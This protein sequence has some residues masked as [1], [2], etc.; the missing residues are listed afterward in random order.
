MTG[1][2]RNQ[3]TRA[4]STDVRGA[5]LVE[6]AVVVL[7]LL[8]LVFGIIEFGLLMK[9]YLLLNHAAREGARF[10]AL[11]SP[12]SGVITR[13]Q[14]SAPTLNQSSLTTTLQKRAMG[15]TP[16]AWVALGNTTDGLHNDAGQGDEVRAYLTYSHQLATGGFFSWLFGSGTSVDIHGDM[17][18]R[19]E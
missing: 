18:M 9:D 16:G 2:H 8:T 1:K 6:F 5:A 12:T 19:R 4:I 15:A 14:S 17:I 3:R 10:A 13:I 11:G 7:L